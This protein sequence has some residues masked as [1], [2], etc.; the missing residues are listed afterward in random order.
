MI[1]YMHTQGLNFPDKNN[2]QVYCQLQ[3]LRQAPHQNPKGPKSNSGIQVHHRS[4]ENFS[5]NNE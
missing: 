4:G 3:I 5:G 2:H 1:L